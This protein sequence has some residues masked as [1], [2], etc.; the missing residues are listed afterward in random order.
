VNL[1]Y[2]TQTPKPLVECSVETKWPTG[3]MNNIRAYGE[4]PHLAAEA[5]IQVLLS[6]YEWISD[7]ERECRRREADLE[8]V[9]RK[10]HKTLE[11][12]RA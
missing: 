3:G 1:S 5:M 7:E 6:L 2:T 8:T 4:T 12:A 9:I 10:L 11:E